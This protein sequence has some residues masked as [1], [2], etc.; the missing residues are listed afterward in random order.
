[1]SLGIY[2]IFLPSAEQRFFLFFST[3]W[4]FRIPSTRLKFCQE[5]DYKFFMYHKVASSKTSYLEAQAGFCRL[6]IKGIFN[7]YAL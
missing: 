2:G 3:Q 5:L 7:P 4:D 6:L 1:M